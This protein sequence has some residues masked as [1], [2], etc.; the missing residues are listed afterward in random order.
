MNDEITVLCDVVD[1]L[2]N[3][4]IPYMLTGSYAMAF[5]TLP[6]MT[7][8]IDI[9]IEISSPEAEKLNTAFS[10]TYYFDLQTLHQ[11]L[12]THG[13]FNIIHQSLMIKVDLIVKKPDEYRRMEFSRRRHIPYEGL[14]VWV[15]AP[16]DLILSKL[17]WIVDSGSE[18]QMRDVR[19]LLHASLD[20]DTDYLYDWAARLSV[21]HLL[22]QAE[23]HA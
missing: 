1:R 4:G 2:D 3:A 10:D 9:I 14:L 6:R 7:R 17:L 13:M 8:D 12:A 11:S 20:L 16:E 18:M 5:Y 22:K 21:A 19:H 23:S 15:V